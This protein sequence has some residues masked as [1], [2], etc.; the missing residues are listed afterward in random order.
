MPPAWLTRAVVVATI[1]AAKGMG[2]PSRRA[3]RVVIWSNVSDV[4]REYGVPARVYRYRTR[5]PTR[6][7]VETYRR[8]KVVI[9]DPRILGWLRRNYPAFFHSRR[10]L[11]FT[12]VIARVLAAVPRWHRRLA[13]LIPRRLLLRVTGVR[14]FKWR[15]Y[16][17]VRKRRL[18]G[19]LKPNWRAM[20]WY[21]I[22]AIESKYGPDWRDKYYIRIAT[23]QWRRKSS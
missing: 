6:R 1:M 16:V 15:V 9:D 10:A 3:R 22:M 20:L 12:S 11:R 14:P 23:R 21:A 17:A 18:V 8:E 19:E 13:E 5:A 7:G 2:A 4:L